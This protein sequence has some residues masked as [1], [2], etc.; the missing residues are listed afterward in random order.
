MLKLG[1]LFLLVR[2]PFLSVLLSKTVF[3][4]V[5][6]S[7][8]FMSSPCF[9][10]SPES[11]FYTQSVFYTQSGVLILYLVRI[12]YPV[13]SPWSAVRSPCF[14]LTD[15]ETS[16]QKHLKGQSTYSFGQGSFLVAGGKR[17]CH[18]MMPK[19]Y[20]RNADEMLNTVCQKADAKNQMLITVCQKNTCQRLM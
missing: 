6:R 7:P 9:I 5:V 11:S 10:L 4:Y 2:F 3:I 1:L 13:C 19:S 16:F 18:R 12:L 14:I 8:H 17:E 20:R 15:L